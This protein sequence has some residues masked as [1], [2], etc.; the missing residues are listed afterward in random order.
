MNNVTEVK[1]NDLLD[2]SGE[3]REGKRLLLTMAHAIAARNSSG[4]GLEMLFGTGVNP[5]G[6]VDLVVVHCCFKSEL[7]KACEVVKRTKGS[8]EHQ[9]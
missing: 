1:F 7:Q 9:I 3:L 8:C 5:V 6:G 4:D 2:S